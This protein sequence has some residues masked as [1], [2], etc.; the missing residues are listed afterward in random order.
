MKMLHGRKKWTQKMKC[1]MSL[2]GWPGCP[3]CP[4]DVL[5]VL[6][7]CPGCPGWIIVQ[8]WMSRCPM[9]WIMS[10]M[11]WMSSDSGC[12]GCPGCPVGSMNPDSH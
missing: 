6:S 7:G 3:G 12:P 1:L 11:S 5:D 4:W 10:W 8:H 9:S 2:S